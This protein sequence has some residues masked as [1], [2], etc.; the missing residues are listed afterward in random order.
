MHRQCACPAD[1][2]RPGVN[3][4]NQQIN[5]STNQQINKKTPV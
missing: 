3:S 2:E 4:T 5:K 1:T